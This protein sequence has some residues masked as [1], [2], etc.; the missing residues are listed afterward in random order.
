MAADDAVA[1]WFNSGPGF[2]NTTPHAVHALADMA[3]TAQQSQQTLT[4]GVWTLD[5]S[6]PVMGQRRYPMLMRSIGPSLTAFWPKSRIRQSLFPSALLAPRPQI[7]T[8]SE[9]DCVAR[10][11]AMRS[12]P[13]W[14][15]PV[16]N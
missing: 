14:S 9:V 7:C 5:S 16:V 4:G 8:Q 2:G 3:T 13:G 11:T 1:P 6:F 10:S 12:T 15:K